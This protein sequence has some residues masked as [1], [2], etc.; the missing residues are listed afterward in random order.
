MDQQAV[1]LQRVLP[2]GV[3]ARVGEGIEI[4]LPTSMLFD[5]PTDAIRATGARQLRDLA[6]SVQEYPATDL[7]IIGLVAAGTTD[8]AARDLMSR[9]ARATFDYLRIHGVKADRMRVAPSGE[10]VRAEQERN[11]LK[12]ARVQIAIVSNERRPI[13]R[14]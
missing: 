9:R 14:P 3:V 1:E 12:S 2:A 4:G 10:S 8:S 6:A 13:A 7:L 11:S 5:G